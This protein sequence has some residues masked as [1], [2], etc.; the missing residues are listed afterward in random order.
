MRGW[1]ALGLV[2]GAALGACA[3]PFPKP[4]PKDGDPTRYGS[5]FNAAVTEALVQ[6]LTGQNYYSHFGEA[7]Y[8][9]AAA[10]PPAPC[11]PDSL[12]AYL[13]KERSCWV[14]MRR[15]GSDCQDSNLC[16]EFKVDPRIASDQA[17]WPIIEEALRRPCAQLTPPRELR[18]SRSPSAV[19]KS[20]RENYDI[21]DCD[22]RGVV[23]QSISLA[24]DYGSILVR[25][26]Q[27]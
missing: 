26:G 14:L 8:G 10:W 3:Q 1:V 7:A 13:A 12:N 6:K 9:M 4:A 24:G 19:G 16:M 11:T 5:A 23:A 2:L 20:A 27:G 15:G 17:L 21:L 22:G 25:F 18:Y